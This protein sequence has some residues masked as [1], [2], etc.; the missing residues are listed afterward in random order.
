MRNALLV[1]F[2]YAVTTSARLCS[3]VGT[4]VQDVVVKGTKPRGARPAL[5]WAVRVI[6]F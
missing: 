1:E 6:K 2:Y 3:L 4:D 5:P